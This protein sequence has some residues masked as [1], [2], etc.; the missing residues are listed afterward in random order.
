MTY[1]K[2]LTLITLAGKWA[3][4]FAKVLYEAARDG[5]IEL[6][7]VEGVLDIAWPRDV[8]GKPVVFSLPFYRPKV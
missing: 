4:P 6:E 5:K 7:E 3:W 1:L 2:F 8:R